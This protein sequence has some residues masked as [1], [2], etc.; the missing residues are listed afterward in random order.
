MEA[1]YYNVVRLTIKIA[2]TIKTIKPKNYKGY[3]RL[4]VEAVKLAGVDSSVTLSIFTLKW[5]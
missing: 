2:N 1:L 4:C 5:F 3:V